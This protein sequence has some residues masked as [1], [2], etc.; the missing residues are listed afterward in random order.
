MAIDFQSTVDPGVD[1][2]VVSDGADAA[3]AAVNANSLRG[4]VLIGMPYIITIS[5]I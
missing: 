4:S 2:P 1:E 3:D 5:G